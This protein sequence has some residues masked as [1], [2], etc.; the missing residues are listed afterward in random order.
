MGISVVASGCNSANTSWKAS[1]SRMCD[2]VIGNYSVRYQLTSGEG[3]YVT[4]FTSS[5]RATLENLIPNAKYNVEVA[6]VNSNGVMS[7]Y[8]AVTQLSVQGNSNQQLCPM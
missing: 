6:S 3:G 2:A 7:A 5:S 1:V 8:S 4:V